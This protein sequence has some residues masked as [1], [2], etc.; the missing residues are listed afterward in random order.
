M[1]KVRKQ[2]VNMY[3]VF[4]AQKSVTSTSAPVESASVH[5]STPVSAS[6]FTLKSNVRSG[7]RVYSDRNYVY[8]QLPDFLQGKDYLMMKNADKF[9]KGSNLFQ[10][11]YSGGVVVYVG[12]DARL[13]STPTWLVQQGYVDT[14]TTLTI[15]QGAN[16]RIGFKVFKKVTGR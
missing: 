2:N 5:E 1:N 16:N 15:S 6:H 3:V 8:K 13:K 7:S 4:L 9:S 11:P 12:I 10:C 14:K